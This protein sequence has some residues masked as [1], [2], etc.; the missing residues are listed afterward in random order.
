M[1][2]Q[3]SSTVIGLRLR[4]ARLRRGIPQD[5]LGTLIGLDEGSA[6]ARISRYESGIH[7]PPYDIA[8]KLAEVLQVQTA[9]LYCD[10]DAVAE[11]L[12]AW[13]KKERAD[14]RRLREAVAL[15]LRDMAEDAD[16]L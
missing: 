11:L 7:A 5:R 16:G 13:G 8:T 1:A 3:N 4:Q 14:N 12:L 6:S 10:D 2:K 15:L 9:F